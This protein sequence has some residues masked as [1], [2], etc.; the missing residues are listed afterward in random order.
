MSNVCYE[1]VLRALDLILS[2][3]GGWPLFCFHCQVWYHHVARLAVLIR[4]KWLI[5]VRMLLYMAMYNNRS[6]TKYFNVEN[7]SLD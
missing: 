2:T 1:Q 7:V 4:A 3:L 5:F 6:I